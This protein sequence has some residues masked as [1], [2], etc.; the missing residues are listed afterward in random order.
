MPKMGFVLVETNPVTFD[1][2]CTFLPENPED[3][4]VG[5]DINHLNSA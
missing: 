4:D 2:I 3:F 5:L 1:A